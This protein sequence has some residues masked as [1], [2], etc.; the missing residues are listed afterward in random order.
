MLAG[1]SVEKRS[2]GVKEGGQPTPDRMHESP[3]VLG[4]G[5]SV[6]EGGWLV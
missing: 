2:L 3:V 4:G 5:V 1:S 6:V